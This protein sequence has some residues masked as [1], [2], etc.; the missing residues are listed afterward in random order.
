M[1]LGA[2]SAPAP[3]AAGPLR[4]TNLHAGSRDK[5][6]S[7]LSNDCLAGLESFVD[8]GLFPEPLAGSDGPN[9]DVLVLLNHIH[10]CAVLPGLDGLV[11]NQN[12]L[13]LFAQAQGDP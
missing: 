10:E 8:D 6:Q 12:G 13:W 4:L 2:F 3:T 9:L 7:S 5:P 1:Y 11:R